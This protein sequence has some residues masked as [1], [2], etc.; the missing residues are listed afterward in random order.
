[1]TTDV[2]IGDDRLELSRFF[3]YPREAVF[4][5]WTEANQVEQWW[6]CRDTKKVSS[7]IDLRVGGEFTHVM[8]VHGQ[9]MNYTGRYTELVVPERI[10]T[11]S[12][13]GPGMDSKVTVE[14]FEEEGGTRVKLTQVGLPPM[15]NIGDIIS[16]G[17]GDAFE[18]LDT[19]LAA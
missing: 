12:S 3:A 2:N 13:M 17:F 18:K 4:E 11:E 7:T 1:M 5:A 10:V 19:H 14:F 9:E 16:R 15:P 6:G 8:L